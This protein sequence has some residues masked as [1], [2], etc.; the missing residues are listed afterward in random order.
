MLAAGLLWVSNQNSSPQVSVEP[1]QSTSVPSV[2]ATPSGT[3]KAEA[4]AKTDKRAAKKAADKQSEADSGAPKLIL[5][6]IEYSP[7]GCDEDRYIGVNVIETSGVVDEVVLIWRAKEFDAE[8][9]RNLHRKD[10][11]WTSYVRGI[12]AD[13]DV[14]L[15]AIA[16]GPGGETTLGTN[17]SRYC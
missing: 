16:S 15:L 11:Q 13:T 7:P 4:K 9:T 17:I 12:P 10:Q 2:E 3:A 5:D 8:N 14:E 1:T 6:W